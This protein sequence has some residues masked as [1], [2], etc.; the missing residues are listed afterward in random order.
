MLKVIAN[1][2]ACLWRG[3]LGI[4]NWAEQFLRWPFS[5]IF[6]SGGGGMPSPEYKPDVSSAQLLDEF[7][8]A[9]RR[10]A[11]VHDLDRD[12]ISTVTKYA[13]ALPKARPTIDLGGLNKDIRATLLT[14][15][16]NELKALSKAG[17]GAIRKFIAGADHGV[18]GVPVVRSVE[19]SEAPKEMTEHEQVLWKVRSRMLKSENGQQFKLAR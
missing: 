13:S 14:M 3:A 5:I 6:G 11:A 16:D 18:H 8:E 9:R 10:Q 1:A 7:D 17:I 19:I 15:D 2:L 12:G 4:L